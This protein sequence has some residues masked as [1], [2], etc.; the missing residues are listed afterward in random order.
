M[1]ASVCP[2]VDWVGYVDWDVRDFHGYET[3][4]GT[5]YNA[6]LIR[7]QKTALV[8]T[9]KA[10]YH[11]ELLR[12]LAQADPPARPDYIVCNHAEPDHTGALPALLAAFPEAVVVCNRKCQA[13]LAQHYQ[14]SAWQFHVVAEGDELSLGQHTLRF[15]DTPMVHWPE[16]MFTY[17]AQAGLLFSMD[18]FGQ[19]Y[20]SSGRFDDQVPAETLFFEAKQY[21]ANIIMPYG[22]QVAAVLKKIAPLPIQ[23][24]AP[25]HGV[26]WRSRRAEIL[27]RYGQWSSGLLCPKVLVIYDSMWGSTGRMAQAI[28]EGASRP[29]VE[30]QLL[31]LRRTAL[32]RVA[33][34]SL[35]AAAVAFGTPTLNR[36]MMPAVAAALCYLKGLRPAKKAALVFGS[37]G[38]G[39]GGPEELYDRVSELGFEVLGEPLKAQYR[40]SEEVLAQCRQA[41]QLLAERAAQAAQRADRGAD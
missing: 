3:A 19:H 15:I 27:E 18:A 32:V 35:D 23:T 26:I 12:K 5:T 37:Y 28:A 34:E 4:R 20:A 10:P 8:D 33:T 39:R 40:P 36:E 6:Y 9:V 11:G 31:P 7:D 25:A 1:H 13:A 14:T 22:K 29:G 38:W 2:G 21:Y 17:L 30:V 24:I 16:S 41:G